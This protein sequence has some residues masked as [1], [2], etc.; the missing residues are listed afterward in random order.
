MKFYSDITYKLYDSKEELEKDELKAIEEKNK[1]EEKQKEENEA[2]Q[3][4]D[5]EI[6]RLGE[7]LNELYKK[8]EKILE[9]RR[10]RITK[11][12]VTSV[13]LWNIIDDYFNI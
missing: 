11:C 12:V 6:K 1:K 8:K 9:N 4:I 7:K 13:Q 5:S 2:L 3:K 10:K